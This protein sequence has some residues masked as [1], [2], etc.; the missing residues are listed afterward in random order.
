MHPEIRLFPSLFFYHDKLIDGEGFKALEFSR[1]GS[2]MTFAPVCFLDVVESAEERQRTSYV[3]VI[4][5]KVVL[6]LLAEIQ[7]HVPLQEVAVIAP[8]K[9]QV[10]LLKSLIKDEPSLGKVE[11]N[12]QASFYTLFKTQY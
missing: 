5:A 4:E 3:N 10:K 7:I 8:Y 1:S 11:V 12:R 2:T 9:A 6:R